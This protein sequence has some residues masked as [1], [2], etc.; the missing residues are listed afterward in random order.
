MPVTVVV[1]GQYGSEGKGKICAHLALIGEADVMVRCGGPN[2]GH[3][4]DL[5]SRRYELKQV[6]SGFIN[7][8]TRLL[9]AP[10]ALIKLPV[11][12]E[13]IKICELTPGRI[14]IDANVG[15]IESHDAE[16]E[17]GRNLRG[18]L[19]STGVGMGSAVSRRVLR[20]DDF[21]TAAEIPELRTYLSP[22]REE[23]N[24]AARLGQKVVI[25][26]TQG[27][28]LSLYHTE[29]WPFCTSRD[30]TAHSFLAEAGLGARDFDVILAL[31]TYPIR[32]GGNSGPLKNEITWQD[33]QKRSGY[34][35]NLA[36][37]TTTTK[38][39]RRVAEFDWALVERAVAANAPTG[40]AVHGI[41]YLSYKNK[42]LRE[43]S[44]LTVEAQE[45]LKSISK[46]SGVPVWLVGT[47]P[48]QSEIVDLRYHGRSD[49][50]PP[51][52]GSY[53]LRA[54]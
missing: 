43:Y 40:L 54:H 41:D 11:L 28:G 36:E 23:V 42:G 2:S 52:I 30:T 53:E 19:G 10:G 18:R 45:F 16:T 33:V 17:L 51:R 37:Y 48:N 9:I 35:H 31:R 34:P 25:E 46:R 8:Q 27:F 14:G 13:E 32:V 24:E 50:T 1:G 5:G 29:Q 21:R 44:A 7:P 38:R 12:L 6:P 39:L 26:G 3:T 49:E 4:V 22:V 47:G 15:I 20:T